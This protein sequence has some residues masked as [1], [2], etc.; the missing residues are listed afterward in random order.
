LEWTFG[1]RISGPT[2]KQPTRLCLDN[3]E[4]LPSPPS[5]APLL[6]ANAQPARDVQSSVVGL[7]SFPDAQQQLMTEALSQG[8]LLLM[9]RATPKG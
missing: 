6:P 3:Y 4:Y 1:F 7:D 2:L 9:G 5:I 8:L